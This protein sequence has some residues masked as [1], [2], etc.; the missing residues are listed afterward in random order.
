L[1]GATPVD[2]DPDALRFSCSD[3]S[4]TPSAPL[5]IADIDTTY[6][7]VTV[8]L[9]PIGDIGLNATSEDGKGRMCVLSRWTK[10]LEDKEAGEGT[11]FPWDDLSTEFQVN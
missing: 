5:R 6:S 1:D 4:A 7:E 3:A 10:T 8:L 2:F 11:T 9:D